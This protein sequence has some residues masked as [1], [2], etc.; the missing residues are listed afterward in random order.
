MCNSSENLAF[1]INKKQFATQ[2]YDKYNSF[3]S[4]RN[5]YDLKIVRYIKRGR[6]EMTSSLMLTNSRR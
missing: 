1:Y 6:A 2:N 5:R 4:L 3:T